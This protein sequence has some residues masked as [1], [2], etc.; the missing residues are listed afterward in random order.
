[1]VK[2]TAVMMAIRIMIE[3]S[4]DVFMV[5]DLCFLCGLLGYNIKPVEMAMEQARNQGIHNSQLWHNKQV[6]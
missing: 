3:R 2:L 6:C 4:E 1:M 5:F